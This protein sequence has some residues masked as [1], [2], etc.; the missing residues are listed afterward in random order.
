MKTNEIEIGEVISNKKISDI[1]HCGNRGG[2]RISTNLNLIVLIADYRNTTY[3]TNWDGNVLNFIAAGTVSDQSLS[4]YR[5][6]AL[7][8]AKKN[9]RQIHLFEKYSAN[10]NIYRG[11]VWV[12]GKPKESRGLDLN[13]Q[14]R[15]I[16]IF[17]LH[18]YHTAI[19][20]SKYFPLEDITIKI[21]DNASEVEASINAE[22][23]NQLIKKTSLRQAANLSSKYYKV[24][25]QQD[26]SYR[27][28]R[29]AIEYSLWR[30]Y[31]STEVERFLRVID[32]LA[33]ENNI[34]IV[35]PY[36]DLQRGSIESRLKIFASIATISAGAVT[37]IDGTIDGLSKYPEAKKNI[38]IVLADVDN[39]FKKASDLFGMNKVITINK[40]VPPNLPDT[41]K[42]QLGLPPDLIEKK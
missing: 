28:R 42:P 36:F 5:N 3:L 32:A 8:D 27:L 16:F 1:F 12:E 40:K 25:Q 18:P 29:E 33:K 19:N 13:N 7:V 37:V 6:K 23:T 4:Y 15:K 34:E 35:I 2:I 14:D 11:I 10:T 31:A 38:P 9:G 41:P 24:I 17:Q 30:A 26:K 21:F 20:E 39:L 22:A